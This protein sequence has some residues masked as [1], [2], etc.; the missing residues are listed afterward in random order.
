MKSATTSNAG[1]CVRGDVAGDGAFAVVVDADA[2]A[3]AVA[4]GAATGAAEAAATEAGAAAAAAVLV[5]GDTAG[6]ATG[7]DA[8]SDADA[9]DAGTGAEEAAVLPA[10]R[11][12]AAAA[13]DDADD[14]DD[15]RGLAT[16]GDLAGDLAGDV[17]PALPGDSGVRDVIVSD[18]T[19]EC[20]ELRAT[21]LRAPLPL[22]VDV[23]MDLR[24]ERSDRRSGDAGRR[25]DG[26][27]GGSSRFFSARSSRSATSD[28]DGQPPLA[29][30]LNSSL[31]PLSRTSVTSKL[32]RR[33]Y[34][35]RGDDVDVG[36]KSDHHHEQQ[37]HGAA[38]KQGRVSTRAAQHNNAVAQAATPTLRR[39]RETPRA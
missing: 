26:G 33:G 14:A 8:R 23:S 22:D 7:A 4:A 35:D 21:G 11:L 32:P 30:L 20:V 9:A 36:S 37:Q 3:D 17:G 31:R 38:T 10:A 34:R 25:C 6:A 19:V 15:R 28:M 27:D 13:V 16:A 5:R 1:V 24:D 39:R 2:G 29:S 12:D 18:V